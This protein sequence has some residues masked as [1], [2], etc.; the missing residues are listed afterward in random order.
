MNAV[1][2]I[3]TTEDTV[4]TED[5]SRKDFSSVSSVVESEHV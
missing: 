3:A 5:R 1:S 4:D 2:K